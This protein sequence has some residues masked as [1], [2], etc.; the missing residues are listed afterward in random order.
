M[1]VALSNP[2]FN[3]LFL[4]NAQTTGSGPYT[5]TW[6]PSKLVTAITAELGIDTDTDQVIQIQRCTLLDIVISMAQDEAVRAKFNFQFGDTPATAGTSLDA[7]I[8]VDDIQTPYTFA[9]GFILENPAG[10]PV[11]EVQA[12]ELT[13]NPNIKEVPEPNS[14]KAVNAAKA[15]LDI[16][17]KFTLTVKDNTW[18]NRVRA[19]QEPTDNVLRFKF[20]NGLSG[21]NERTLY[22]DITGLGLD[23]YSLPAI[24]VDNIVVADI[25]FTGRT[26]QAKAINN[27]S[28]PP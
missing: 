13:V 10:T 15:A 6:D 17:G 4:G 25:P 5:H 23:Q 18:Y 27:T 28:S 7:S 26:I 14:P 3:D 22:Y 21:T 12:A 19:R 16:F 8:V 11:A 24:D 1:D 9:A 2:W 20:T